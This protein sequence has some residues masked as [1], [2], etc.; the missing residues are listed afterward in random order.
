MTKTIEVENDVVTGNKFTCKDCI[1]PFRT[2]RGLKQHMRTCIKHNNESKKP[3][4]L[5]SGFTIL[6]TR[7]T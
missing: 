2:S 4:D 7:V 6:L 5:P 1:R 3:P